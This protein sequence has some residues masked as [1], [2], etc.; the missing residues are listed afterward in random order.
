MANA[1]FFLGLMTALPEE[2]G[3]VTKMMSFDCAKANFFNAARYG[4]QSQLVWID[5]KSRR[6]G[7][8]ILEELL[9]RARRGLEIAEID[10]SDIDRLLGIIEA[11][12]ALERS[13]S[14]W[15][16]ES[17]AN[18]DPRAKA[19]V[20][21]RS[22]TA[23]MKANQETLRPLHEWALAEIPRKPEWID[24]YETVEQ[25][26]STDLFTVRP[27]D[28]IDLA[29]SLMHWKHVRHVPVEDDNGEL[30]GI[31]SHRDLLELLALGKADRT[32]EIIVRDIMRKELVTI[33]PETSALGRTF[34][35]AGER[36]RVPPDSQRQEAGRAGNGIR[37]SY[38]FRKTLRRKADGTPARFGE[39]KV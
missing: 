12:A 6:A 14:Q 17:L 5:G 26:M 3:D 4:M 21:M 27:E 30:V 13:G 37:L 1:A 7:R 10:A 18:M 33:S 2:F 38:G 8:L 22:L 19:N 25:F 23:A 9:P 31:V 39:T 32:G 29:A 36:Y 15:M 35:Y 34:P 16:L 24:N 11:R 20:R 28:V